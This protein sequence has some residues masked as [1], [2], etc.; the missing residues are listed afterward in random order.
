MLYRAILF[1]LIILFAE[2]AFSQ[3]KTQKSNQ[4][5][6]VIIGNVM[7]AT[8]S[9]PIAFSTLI[10]VKAAD[11]S[12]KIVQI[13]DKNGAFEFEKIPF[14]VYSLIVSA[15]GYKNL[16]LDSIQVRAERYDFNLGDVNLLQHLQI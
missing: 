5:F 2:T 3:E 7:D 4:D 8:T 1:F 10:L 15:T 16:S 11:T 13:A 9:K 14:A 6:G 12:K